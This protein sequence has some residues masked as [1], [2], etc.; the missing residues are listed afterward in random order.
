MLLNLAH[1]AG[2]LDQHSIPAILRLAHSGCSVGTK[3]C[4][5]VVRIHV[6]SLMLPS[7]Y[8]QLFRIL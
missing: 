4:A 7:L 1:L 3:V 8:C 2:Y 5:V 6:S